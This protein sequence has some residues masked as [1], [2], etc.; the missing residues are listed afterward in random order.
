MLDAAVFGTGWLIT[1][2]GAEDLS[3]ARAL[4]WVEPGAEGLTHS[5][6]TFQIGDLVLRRLLRILGL[7]VLNPRWG[8]CDCVCLLLVPTSSSHLLDELRK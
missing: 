3:G 6:A 5:F 1:K 2:I 7:K 8:I 4:G